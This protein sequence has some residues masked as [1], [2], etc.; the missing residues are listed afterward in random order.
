MSNS[1]T[2]DIATQ[3]ARSSSLNARVVRIGLHRFR[4]AHE[5]HTARVQKALSGPLLEV[6]R[7]P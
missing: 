3:V 6:F 1:T 2:A 4:N 5:Q 7:A